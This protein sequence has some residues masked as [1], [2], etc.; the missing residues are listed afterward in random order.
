MLH[1][2]DHAMADPAGRCEIGLLVEPIHQKRHRGRMIGG[3]EVAG[4]ALLT[5]DIE[6]QLRAAQ[7]NAIDISVRPALQWVSYPIERELDAR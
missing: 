3:V 6:C 2:V 5:R 1:A 7:P 4:L